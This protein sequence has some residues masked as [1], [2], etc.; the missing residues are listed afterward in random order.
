MLGK[1]N[2]IQR[3]KPVGKFFLLCIISCIMAMGIFWLVTDGEYVKDKHLTVTVSIMLIFGIY[4]DFFRQKQSAFH[5][6]ILAIIINS[7]VILL[8][9]DVHELLFF[10]NAFIYVI[11][12]ADFCYLLDYQEH[13]TRNYLVNLVLM[14]L[15]L[16][17]YI[18]SLAMLYT[19]L[20]F[21]QSV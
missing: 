6:A 10:L 15:F 20:V 21:F 16:L 3:E 2:F 17:F 5:I 12:I 7:L 18:G 4:L 9:K 19:V 14:V 13:E 11:S 1:D 8:A